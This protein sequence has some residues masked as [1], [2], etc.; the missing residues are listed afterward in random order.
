MNHPKPE[1]WV[2]YL[3]EEAEPQAQRELKAHLDSCPQ[4]RAELAGWEQSLKR[5]DAWRLPRAGSQPFLPVAMLKWG[6]AAVALLLLGYVAGHSTAPKADIES[7]S[8]VLEPQLRRELTSELTRVVY[9]EVNKAA[10]TTLAQAEEQC[11]KALAACAATI[12]SRHAEDYR[13]V[14]AALMLLKEQLDTV[15]MNTDAGFRQAQ[16]KFVHLAD[17]K[18]PQRSSTEE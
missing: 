13:D 18:Q 9:A 7:V 10:V 15:A 11:A 17:Y 12:D 3:Y 14:H 16:Q 1:E 8:S 4:C 6:A 5:L 2:T